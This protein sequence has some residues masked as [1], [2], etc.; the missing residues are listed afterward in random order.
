RKKGLHSRRNMLIN[1]LGAI[2]TAITVIV[3]IGSKFSE[4]AWITL[5][6]IPGLIILM[7]GI[8]RHYSRVA[9]AMAGSK[10]LSTVNL[11]PPLVVVPIEEWN[12][13]S[14]KAVRFALTLSRDI[15]AVHIDSEEE[16][17]NLAKKW[18]DYVEEPA[19]NAG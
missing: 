7:F 19:R 17:E 2:V 3:I 13:V 15:V 12:R 8:R 4:G 5:L 10:V 14:Q 6:L 11:R 9:R 18:A 16:D 1:G